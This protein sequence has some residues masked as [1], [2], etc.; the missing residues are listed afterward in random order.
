MMPQSSKIKQQNV[1]PFFFET[2]INM[3]LIAATKSM[4]YSCHDT[5]ISISML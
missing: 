1:F 4:Q 3:Q 2:A 5:I